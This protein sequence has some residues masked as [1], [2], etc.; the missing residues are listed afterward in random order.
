MVMRQS[1][2]YIAILLITVMFLAASVA[3][4]ISETWASEVYYESDTYTEYIIEPGGGKY[5]PPGWCLVHGYLR[6]LNPDD[7]YVCL[8]CD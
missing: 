2:L 6:L 3:F 5:V 7:P 4:A 1:K 8:Q